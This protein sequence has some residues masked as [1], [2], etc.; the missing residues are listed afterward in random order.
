MTGPAGD[1]LTMLVVKRWFM[2]YRRNWLANNSV[3]EP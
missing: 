2:G 1:T 3:L